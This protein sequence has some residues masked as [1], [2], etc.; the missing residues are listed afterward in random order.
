MCHVLFWHWG[1]RENRNKIPA[2]VDRAAVL[3]SSRVGATKL[4]VYVDSGP[5]KLA[6]YP[7]WLLSGNCSSIDQILYLSSIIEQRDTEAYFGSEFPKR[8]EAYSQNFT[9][10]F[11]F[12]NGQ[13]CKTDCTLSCL[14]KQNIPIRPNLFLM[15]TFHH[16]KHRLLDCA[17]ILWSLSSMNHAQ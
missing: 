11:S 2:P 6:V 15:T 7:L 13:L 16:L 9:K 8:N 10:C 12:L 4:G 17:K 5:L 14:A 3:H 1:Y